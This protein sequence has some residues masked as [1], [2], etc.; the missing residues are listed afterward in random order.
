MY[1]DA[2]FSRCQKYRYVLIREWQ[3]DLPR[4]AFVMLN[5]S[6]ADHLKDDPT[7]SRS[8]AFAKSWGFGALDIY[9][10]FAYRSPYPEH[11]FAQKDPIGPRNYQ[12][13]RRLKD[14]YGMVLCAW[15]NDGKRMQ[16]EEGF[17][18]RFKQQKLHC[19]KK[20]KSG[21]PAHPLYIRK[22]VRPIPYKAGE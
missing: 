11:L 22:D 12:Y 6:T 16:Q 20:N 7:I 4:A 2:I 8:I 9:N 21:S 5:P 18:K 3:S 19:L 13:L 1:R 17:L 15:G 14:N 10:L